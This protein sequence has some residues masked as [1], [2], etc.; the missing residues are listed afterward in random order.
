[1][2]MFFEAIFCPM[3]SFLSSPSLSIH[4]FGHS[5]PGLFCPPYVHGLSTLCP[6]LRPPFLL[7]TIPSHEAHFLD[8]PPDVG[9][10]MAI[11]FY[12]AAPLALFGRKIPVTITIRILWAGSCHTLGSREKL[13]SALMPPSTPLPPHPREGADRS[14]GPLH[15]RQVPG[16]G[17]WGGWH[18]PP[19]RALRLHLWLW[20]R[21]S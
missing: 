10:L 4:V 3:L 6:A 13:L 1:M 17:I 18:R 16:R 21:L 2:F 8:G 15:S 19:S 11:T 7:S 20:G 12:T 9:S 14:P 5:F